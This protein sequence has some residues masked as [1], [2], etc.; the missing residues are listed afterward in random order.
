M[1]IF[2]IHVYIYMYIYTSMYLF[3]NMFIYIYMY[4]Y[5]VILVADVRVFEP[6]LKPNT[7]S[8]LSSYMSVLWKGHLP[9]RCVVLH[10]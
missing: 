9:P 10:F 2:Y 4:T 6:S 3:T 7:K 5:M 1:H 8:E